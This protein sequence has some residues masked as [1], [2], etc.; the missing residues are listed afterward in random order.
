[1]TPFQIYC[2]KTLILETHDV[3][4]SFG[5]L[6]FVL[7]EQFCHIKFYFNRNSSVSV[8]LHKHCCY[9]RFAVKAFPFCELA[10][11]HIDH[12]RNDK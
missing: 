10:V 11:F 7:N 5:N 3:M 9:Q 2:L 6:C 4:R 12:N 1:M 8:C